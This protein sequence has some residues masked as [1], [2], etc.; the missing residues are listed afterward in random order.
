MMYPIPT[1][2][3]VASH[4]A[5]LEEMRKEPSEQKIGRPA[6]PRLGQRLALRVSQW[7]ISTGQRMYVRNRPESS[8]IPEVYRSASAS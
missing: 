7:L 4:D 3:L 5:W 6:H 1:S 8:V 2:L